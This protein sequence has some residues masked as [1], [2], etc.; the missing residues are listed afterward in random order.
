MCSCTPGGRTLS[1]L[2]LITVFLPAPYRGGTLR[3][4]KSIAKMIQLG[5]ESSGEPC[6]VRVAILPNTYDIDRDFGDLI[7]DRIDIREVHWRAVGA[8]EV[9]AANI[10]QGREVRLEHDQY[11]LPE[12]GINNCMD[13]DLWL[14]VSDR[15]GRP[16]APVR[17][18]AIFATDYIQR[19]I[20]HIFST[21][22]PG[23][24]DLSYLQSVRQADAVIVTTPHTGAD[25]VTYAGVPQKKVHLAPMDFDPSPL[26]GHKFSN[27][28][29]KPY[30]VWPTNPTRHKNHLR[31]FEA[32]RIYYEELDGALGVQVT[33]PHTHWM[34][35]EHEWRPEYGRDDYVKRIRDAVDASDI[36][37]ENVTFG[38]EMTDRQ[39]A[40]T[41]SG[42]RF[43]W[44]PTLIDNGTFV[45]A[46]A[47]FLGCPSL[48]SNYPP[49][50]YI[51]DRFGLPTVFFDAKVPQEM[52]ESLKTMEGKEPALRKELPSQED[53]SRYS[54]R[55][56]AAEYWDIL[57]RASSCAA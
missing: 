34:D 32:L 5:S 7:A 19:Y 29:A 55:G 51:S 37:K 46:E 16:L 8:A 48:S 56:Y 54:W 47:A 26:M 53:L 49:M 3:V 44:H 17:P 18:Y 25:V 33:G 57:K 35:P 2:K 4:T 38:G 52:A 6:R 27:R 31:A 28:I 24:A 42:A 30:I 15:L 14:V 11:F 41:L 45:V 36:L 1:N 20:P 23:E 13:S 10:L 40:Q 12:D 43:L 39:Y 22:V 50:R 21:P 9:R